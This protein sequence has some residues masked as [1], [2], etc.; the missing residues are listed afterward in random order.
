MFTKVINLPLN[1]LTESWS[2]EAMPLNWAAT[3]DAWNQANNWRAA[4]SAS[5]F[6]L[7]LLAFGLRLQSVQPD[8]RAAP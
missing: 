7:A 6:V 4:I 5:V 8:H 1:H 3:R 2:P